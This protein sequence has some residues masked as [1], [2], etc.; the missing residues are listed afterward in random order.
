MAHEY[1]HF[2]WR[3][4][5]NCLISLNNHASPACDRK[6]ASSSMREYTPLEPFVARSLDKTSDHPTGMNAT[7]EKVPAFHRIKEGLK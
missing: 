2:V 5:E 7:F 6:N 1:G 3:N 4:L